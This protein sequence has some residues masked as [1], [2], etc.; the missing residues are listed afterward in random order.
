MNTLVWIESDCTLKPGV[1]SLMNNISYRRQSNVFEL[2][3]IWFF[4]LP[5]QLVFI[6]MTLRWS[7]V[8]FLTRV[9]VQKC[10]YDFT[11]TVYHFSL[12][13]SDLF[14]L[15]YVWVAWYMA[16][17]YPVCASSE[18]RPRE[19]VARRRLKTI[20]NSKTLDLKVVMVA[21]LQEVVAYQ[22]FQLKL[23]DWGNF[24][25]LA[26]W[27]LT[28]GGHLREVV[29]PWFTCNCLHALPN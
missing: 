29:N 21:I 16:S 25:I 28:G 10:M 3:L 4:R 22:R 1:S 11:H 2:I 9:P 7:L 12:H 27:P 20:K 19:V 6:A 14:I 26:K 5:L 15:I 18:I 24:G 23:F 13:N 17:Y 8:H